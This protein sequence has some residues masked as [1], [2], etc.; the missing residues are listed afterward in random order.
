[1]QALFEDR[2]GKRQCALCRTLTEPLQS[3]AVLSINCPLTPET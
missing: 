1:L 2:S 3:C